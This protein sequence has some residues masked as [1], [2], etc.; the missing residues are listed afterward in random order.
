MLIFLFFSETWIAHV[1]ENTTGAVLGSVIPTVIITNITKV[2]R[3]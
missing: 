3:Q 1:K 2:I